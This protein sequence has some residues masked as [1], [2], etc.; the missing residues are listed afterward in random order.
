MTRVAELIS[1][2]E[3]MDETELGRSILAAA[4]DAPYTGRSGVVS[5]LSSRA[6]PSVELPLRRLSIVTVYAPGPAGSPIG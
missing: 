3:T 4:T 5:F 2:I 1:D 6:P